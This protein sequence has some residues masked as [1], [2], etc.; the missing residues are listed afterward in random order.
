MSRVVK[1]LINIS[2]VLC[3]IATIF[4]FTPYNEYSRDNMWITNKMQICAHRGGALLNPENTKKAFDYVIKETS[5]TDIVE[6]DLRLTKDNVIVINHDSDINRM[7][8]DNSFSNIEIEE[9]TY[10]ELQN[11]NLGRNFIDLNGN[12]PYLDY[13]IDQAKEI[14]LTLMSLDD[15]FITYNEYRDIKVF[16]EIKESVEKGRYIVDKVINDLD[17]KYLWW[18]DKIM[19]ITFEDELIDYIYDVYPSVSSG[20]LGDKVVN[21]IATHILGIDVFYNANYNSIQ[22]P[23]N[24]K[25]KEFPIELANKGF[26]NSFHDRNQFVVYWGVNNKD[27]MEYLINIGVD[28]I[29]TDRPDLLYEILK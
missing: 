20:S 2:L 29:T 15:F 18:K 5:Y 25:A 19:F 24:S 4:S 28:C 12:M 21:Q 26:V 17:T 16:L 8:L 6:I 3:I 1:V 23:Y 27:D 7:A 14:G 11:Y 22:V 13:S 10:L 9:H